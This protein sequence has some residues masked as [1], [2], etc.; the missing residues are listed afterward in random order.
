ML[1]MVLREA[2]GLSATGIA[3][4][5]GAALL[6]TRLVR[7]ML[8][9]LQ[10]TDPLSLAGGAALLVFVALVASWIPAH[11]AARPVQPMDALRHE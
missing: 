8:F 5:L 3:A 9:G 10:P 4:G 2:A 1:A 7:S 6:L 11:R